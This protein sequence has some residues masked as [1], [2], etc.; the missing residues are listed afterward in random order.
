MSEPTQAKISKYTDTGLTE[1][2]GQSS[3]LMTLSEVHF[4]DRNLALQQKQKEHRR[5]LNCFLKKNYILSI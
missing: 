3:C 2:D 1:R 4:E 5:I